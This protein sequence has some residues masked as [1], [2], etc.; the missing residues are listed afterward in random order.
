M[1]NNSPVDP[2]SITKLASVDNSIQASAKEETTKILQ[3]LGM[4]IRVGDELKGGIVSKV[5]AGT[6][7]DT[8]VVIKRTFNVRPSDPTVFETTPDIQ[9]TDNKI[10]HYLASHKDV[11]VPNII[12]SFTDIPV[13]VMEDLRA[14]GFLLY[15]HELID[16]NLH[17]EHAKHVGRDIGNIQKNLSKH[18]PFYTPLSAAQNYY[19]RGLELRLA[20]PN[21]QHWYNKLENRF[22]ND[23]KQLTAVDTHPKNMFVNPSTGAC[24]WIDFGGSTWADRDFALPNFL[25]HVATYAIAG[26]VDRHSAADYIEQAVTAYREVLDID[27]E[28]FMTYFAAEIVHRWAG[29]W[30][31]GIDTPAQKLALLTYGTRIFDES[32]FSLRSGLDLLRQG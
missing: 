8:A 16:G 7:N 9:F 19:A 32:L 30:L 25:A 28:I 1:I 14:S 10:L 31:E 23:N 20:Y 26:Y 15:S 2:V 18:K 5:Y 21:A 17:I 22:V 13:T 4:R 6:Y 11:R 27:D 12:A 3:Q 24:A 29:K